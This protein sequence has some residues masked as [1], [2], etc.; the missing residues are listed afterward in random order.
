MPLLA[1]PGV[2]AEVE[3]AVKKIAEAIKAKH[4]KAAREALRLGNGFVNG[5]GFQKIK[6]ASIRR[7]AFIRLWN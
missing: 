1:N 5:P 6:L 4:P 2:R 7:G 3:L